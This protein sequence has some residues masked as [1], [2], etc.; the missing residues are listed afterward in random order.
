MT[1]LGETKQA[2]MRVTRKPRNLFLFNGKKENIMRRRVLS[3]V[4]VI[5][6]VAA[7]TACG[8]KK[9]ETEEQ[10]DNKKTEAA[11]DKKMDGTEEETSEDA[12]GGE[13]SEEPVG[14]TETDIEEVKASIKE[15]VIKEYLEPN[16]IAPETFSWPVEDSTAW[17]YCNELISIYSLQ[18]FGGID[19]ESEFMPDSPEKE[20]IDATFEGIINWFEASREINRENLN[21]MINA[22]IPFYASISTINVT[23]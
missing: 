18:Q 4:L 13:I 9:E 2:R 12:G 11:E 22:L 14:M 15:S 3:L 5:V 16:G 6:M 20:I 23:E 8:S 17:L 10:E 19:K 7:M 1:K 21:E